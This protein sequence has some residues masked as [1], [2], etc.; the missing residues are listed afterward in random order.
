[1]WAAASGRAVRAPARAHAVALSHRAPVRVRGRHQRGAAQHHRHAGLRPAAEI[2]DA[3]MQ[4]SPTPE[5]EALQEAVARFCREQVTPER[6]QAWQREPGGIDADCW[7][8]IAALG[9]LGLGVPESG[10][11]SGRGLADVAF[12]LQEC[13]RGLVPRR[14]IN[15]IRANWALTQV[16]P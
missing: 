11:G 16:A 14:V 6:L 2:R 10:G 4:L 7:R 9:W 13:A 5:Q 8:A 1:Q 15:A 12:L 3:S